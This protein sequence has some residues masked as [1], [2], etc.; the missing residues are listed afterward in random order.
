[1]WLSGGVH[2]SVF[3]NVTFSVW[4][5]LLSM[6]K[7]EP[8]LNVHKTLLYCLCLHRKLSCFVYSVGAALSPKVALDKWQT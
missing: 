5:D 1:M 8:L 2:T 6:Y 4:F 7:L 3:T